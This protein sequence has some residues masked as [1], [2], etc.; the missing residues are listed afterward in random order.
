MRTCASSFW[1]PDDAYLFQDT[2][3]PM[4]YS[5][6]SQEDC[7]C[8]QDVCQ[9][10]QKDMWR[11]SFVLL[12]DDLLT[13]EQVRELLST[14]LGIAMD[15]ICARITNVPTIESVKQ[16]NIA[17]K[18]SMSFKYDQEAEKEE[19]LQKCE[20]MISNRGYDILS[21]KVLAPGEVEQAQTIS[22]GALRLKSWMSGLQ[23]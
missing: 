21:S 11:V 4:G 6:K 16:D 12:I 14:Q 15:S 8:T 10:E 7:I 2:C 23:F 22:N 20:S 13:E 5:A 17:Q 1:A 19:M 9:E 18:L 3:L